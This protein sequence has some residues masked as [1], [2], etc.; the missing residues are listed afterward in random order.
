MDA[1]VIDDE[2]TDATVEITGRHNLTP[3]SSAN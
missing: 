2:G 3:N 1:R